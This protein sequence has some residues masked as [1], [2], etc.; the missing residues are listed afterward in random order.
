MLVNFFKGLHEWYVVS[1]YIYTAKRLGELLHFRPSLGT[2]LDTKIIQVKDY[3]KYKKLYEL[4]GYAPVPL[5]AIRSYGKYGYD[6]TPYLRVKQGQAVH[7]PADKLDY[8]SVLAAAEKIVGSV[9]TESQFTSLCLAYLA[10]TKHLFSVTHSSVGW[11][12]LLALR[13][14]GD[15]GTVNRHTL[16]EV[17]AAGVVAVQ[18]HDEALGC[19]PTIK[20]I[21]SDQKLA[22][23]AAG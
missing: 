15:N 11:T 19:E 2:N 20:T 12:L 17:L 8:Y 22:L 9:W 6:F 4:L 1:N 18:H 21:S 3:L 5:N 7:I 13:G 16:H 10:N 23:P 14:F